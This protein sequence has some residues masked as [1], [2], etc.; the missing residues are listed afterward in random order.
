MNRPLP[1]N[2][3]QVQCLRLE[4]EQL[5]LIFHATCVVACAA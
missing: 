4:G 3:L 1:H 2:K 5:K